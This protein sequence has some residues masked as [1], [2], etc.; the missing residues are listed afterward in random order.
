MHYRRARKTAFRAVTVTSASWA[1]AEAAWFFP[2]MAH[3]STTREATAIREWYPAA[4]MLFMSGS[5]SSLQYRCEMGSGRNKETKMKRFAKIA[6]GA[7]MIAG[8]A[9]AAA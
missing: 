2:M 3:C 4:L 9:T 7:L 8:A 1:V 6:L 5:A